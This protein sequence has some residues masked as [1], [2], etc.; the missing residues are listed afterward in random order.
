M[1]RSRRCT[2]RPAPSCLKK[3]PSSPKEFDALETE[4]ARLWHQLW[5]F[6]F[7]NDGGTPLRLHPSAAATINEPPRRTNRV[8]VPVARKTAEG[9]K[10]IA[11]VRAKL[12]TLVAGDLANNPEEHQ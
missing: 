10:V 6:A 7:S 1:Q 2:T 8:G 9:Q 5:G 11:E 12:D 3:R 4:A